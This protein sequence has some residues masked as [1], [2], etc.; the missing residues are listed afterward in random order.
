MYV[1]F[2]KLSNIKT[3]YKQTHTLQLNSH[4]LVNVV[5]QL[6]LIFLHHLFWKR[7]FADKWNRFFCGL[8]TL[9]VTQPVASHIRILCM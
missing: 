1:Q 2:V 9:P 8:H 3:V 6:P 5:S 7:I 4:F